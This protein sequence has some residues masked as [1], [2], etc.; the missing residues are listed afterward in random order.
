[1]MHKVQCQD[2]YPYIR[3]CHQDNM[4]TCPCFH[5]MLPLHHLDPLTDT[6]VKDMRILTTPDIPYMV[7]LWKSFP[8]M[9]KCI[10]CFWNHFKC[11]YPWFLLD[12]F[13][14]FLPPIFP[15]IHVCLDEY[16]Q[17]YNEDEEENEI[18]KEWSDDVH[19]VC[20][21][22]LLIQRYSNKLKVP[23]IFSYFFEMSF[24]EHCH[25][26]DPYRIFWK[27]YWKYHFW[28]ILDLCG[29][30]QEK[31]NPVCFTTDRIRNATMNYNKLKR[32]L[33]FS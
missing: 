21:L 25:W 15:K 14:V 29:Q 22:Y 18:I 3:A 6:D 20:C 28:N 7:L 10:D 1:M 19:N 9:F 8:D 17:C 30:P 31:R 2:L 4:G 23:N 5:H 12:P 16:L 24:L 13:P 32:K 33:S 27:V 26:N 11:K